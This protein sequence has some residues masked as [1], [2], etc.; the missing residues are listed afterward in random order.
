[1][2]YYI[3]EQSGTVYGTDNEETAESMSHKPLSV[4][5]NTRENIYLLHPLSFSQPVVILP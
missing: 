5:I 3:I 1:M 4:V 2:K